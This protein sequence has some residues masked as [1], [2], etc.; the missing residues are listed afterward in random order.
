MLTWCKRAPDPLAV[1]NGTL[2]TALVA[3]F[4]I[5]P[6]FAEFVTAGAVNFV[7]PCECQ[8]QKSGSRWPVKTD[9][10]PV[11]LAKSIIQ[12]VMPSQI[13]ELRGP[14]SNM[15]LTAATATRM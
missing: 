5:A 15:S 2:F 6:A 3:A 12:T 14:E 7:S 10:S 13:Y 8:G 1:V 9:T 4:V 11:P